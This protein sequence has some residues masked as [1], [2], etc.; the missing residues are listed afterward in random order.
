MSHL[1][2]GHYAAAGLASLLGLSLYFLKKVGE[3]LRIAAGDLPLPGMPWRPDPH[4][5]L[6]LIE[7]LKQASSPGIDSLRDWLH[8]DFGIMALLLLL[9]VSVASTGWRQPGARRPARFTLVVGGAAVM[10]DL[11]E[12]LLLLNLTSESP[13]PSYFAA[14]AAHATLGKWLMLL[15]AGVTGAYTL[16]RSLGGMREWGL[17]FFQDAPALIDSATRRFDFDLHREY[18]YDTTTGGLTPR[19]APF[20]PIFWAHTLLVLVIALGFT[21][22]ALCTLV[23]A[24]VAVASLAGLAAVVAWLTLRG[25]RWYFKGVKERLARMDERDPAGT[26]DRAQRR[27]AL[28]VAM[29]LCGIV[30]L[31]PL[32]AGIVMAIRLA[33]ELPCGGAASPPGSELPT[34]LALALCGIA[35]WTSFRAQG[36]TASSQRLLY[37]QM[38][39]L[40]LLCA[41]IWIGVAPGIATE[42]TD[43]PYRHLGALL[44]S[45]LALVVCIAPRLARSRFKRVHVDSSAYFKKQLSQTELF[46]ADRGTPDV[47]V[48]SVVQAIIQGNL[49]RPLRSL[50]LPCLLALMAPAGSVTTVFWPTLLLSVLLMTWAS[51]SRRWAQL[52]GLI[53]RWLLSGMTFPVSVLVIALSLL[54]LMNVHYVAII[55]D[56]A[57]LGATLMWILAAYM[58]AWT[59]DYWINRIAAAELLEVL[60]ATQGDSQL[61]YV[62]KSE[63][64]G[65]V[66]VALEGRKLMSH[67]LG[68]LLVV[69]RPTPEN[70]QDGRPLFH[71]YNLLGVFSLLDVAD[72]RPHMNGVS[73]AANAYFYWMNVLLIATIFGFIG[74]YLYWA[75]AESSNPILSTSVVTDAQAPYDL[76]AH[77]IAADDPQPAVIVAASGGGTRA[78]LYAT[79]V[80]HGLH[81]LGADRHVVLLSGV[82]GGGVALSYFAAH[83]DELTSGELD[84]WN[85]FRDGVSRPFI[86]DVIEGAAEWRIFTGGSLTRLLSESLQRRLF[87]ADDAEHCIGPTLGQV[88]RVGLILN[89]AVTGHPLED[90]DL[91]AK[92]LTP[93][94]AS[95]CSSHQQPY[96]LMS[97]GRL[98]FTNL[99]DDEA[100]NPSAIIPDVR[101]PYMVLRDPTI[102]L[103]TAAALNANFPPVFQNAK[104][105]VLD[106]RAGSPCPARAYFVTDGGAEENLGLVS[107]LLSVRSALADLLGK[108]SP[109]SP[110]CP[111]RRG[112]RPLHFVLAEASAVGID[113]QQDRGLSTAF[114]NA[115]ERLTGGLTQ[116]LMADIERLLESLR[117]STGAAASV[118]YHYLPLPLP[119]RSRGG[120]GT[121]WMQADKYVLSDP[122][123]RSA[124]NGL[125]RLLQPAVQRT[126]TLERADLCRVWNALHTPEPG[127]CRATQQDRFEE[128]GQVRRWL[129][130]PPDPHHQA[131]SEL[132]LALKSTTG[133]PGAL[134]CDPQ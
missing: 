25:G 129:C 116:A 113:Y 83:F 102:P 119:F 47:S 17:A 104:V 24:P 90:S 112:L 67:G 124:A 75:D 98:V 101:L 74:I 122:R 41:A 35:V 96:A 121:H 125:Q 29:A 7:R 86:E 57:P 1:K 13:G 89:T 77:L 115:K 59:V 3:P 132:A 123:A 118:K 20:K 61:D 105:L 22:D 32:I 4:N 16:W 131:W 114:G 28:G 56:A 26:Q 58:L 126:V 103:A 34:A 78:A 106:A 109:E 69:G 2:A 133:D 50:L 91:L 48:A 73:R 81:R 66:K 52:A 94:E 110:N 14:W 5:T 38:G 134:H 120:V 46:V 37:M 70:T 11:A 49:Y 43:R 71:S 80:L 19:P 111:A 15:A 33:L 31:T 23:P 117:K 72:G 9:F 88:D 85:R 8:Q 84:R 87:C 63:S 55:L 99:R 130:A 42:M 6:A 127:F 27:P 68:R 65:K 107:A 39:T 12:N 76:T 21:P 92:V 100:F 44:I 79:H 60:G 51:L 45:A 62:F 36:K 54:R 30:V 40:V 82:S 10:T 53:E 108:C 64:T 97:G 95:D 128:M 18:R 93:P